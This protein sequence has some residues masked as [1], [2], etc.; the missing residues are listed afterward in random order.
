MKSVPS[1]SVGAPRRTPPAPYYKYE[2]GRSF[3]DT[4]QALV[5]I[6]DLCFA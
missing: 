4:P 1:E 5:Y 2:R 3:E 6:L